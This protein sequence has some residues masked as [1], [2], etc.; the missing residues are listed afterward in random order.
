MY[1]LSHV[2]LFC[3]PMTLAC[4]APL[5]M[6]FSRQE[7]WSELPFPTLRDLLTQ[8]LSPQI[9]S[10]LHWQADSFITV[11]PGKPQECTPLANFT[12]VCHL[13]LY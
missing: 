5:S 10:L 13:I 12:R 11:P 3:N 1:V 8:R 7:C 6:E 2:Q 4:Q 9:S